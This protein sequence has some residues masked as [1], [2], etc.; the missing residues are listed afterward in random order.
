VQVG[1]K[2]GKHHK[3]KTKVTGTQAVEGTRV[4]TATP[5]TAASKVVG[6]VFKTGPDSEPVV[7]PVRR[8][9]RLDRSDRIQEP[10]DVVYNIF[11]F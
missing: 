2:S 5:T 1:L 6:N 11:T 4:P 10:D 3:G 9:D 7:L 8:S